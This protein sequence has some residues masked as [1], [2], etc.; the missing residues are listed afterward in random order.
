MLEIAEE[1]NDDPI[2]WALF[3]STIELGINNLNLIFSILNVKCPLVFK[4]FDAFFESCFWNT[5]KSLSVSKQIF[6]GW[7]LRER[8]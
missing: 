4:H 6:Q 8:S 2:F 3:S 7:I 1:D 5:Q